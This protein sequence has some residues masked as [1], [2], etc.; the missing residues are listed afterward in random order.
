MNLADPS[1]WTIADARV[2][3]DRRTISAS[4]LTRAVLLRV[5][6]L[7]PSLHALLA[8][9][10]ERALADAAAADARGARRA[11]PAARRAD[12]AQGHLRDAR[13]SPPPAARASSTA[14]SPP[15]DAHGVERLATAGA[16]L[17]GKP[18]MDEFA[19][20]SSTENSAFGPARNPW[21]LARV[22]GGSSGGSAA[23]VAAR[24][25]PAR[26]RHRHRRLDPPARGATA[27]SSA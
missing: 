1:T 2:A 9:T 6:A 24:R 5:A 18:N 19:M 27:A 26:A 12:R 21:D 13:A 16:S 22:P 17:I 23:A 14:S 15:Y 10:T 11:R 3:L 25:V 4:E 8:V 7:E 20:G